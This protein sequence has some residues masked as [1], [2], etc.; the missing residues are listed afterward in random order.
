M[1]LRDTGQDSGLVF[2]RWTMSLQAHRRPA[3]IEGRIWSDDVRTW[4]TSPTA[5][6]R[7]L[8]ALHI[9]TRPPLAKRS[10]CAR[11]PG[12]ARATP[13]RWSFMTSTSNPLSAFIRAQLKIA[14]AHAR[15]APPA[16]APPVAR[17][18]VHQVTIQTRDVLD[19]NALGT[20]LHSAWL[21]QPP[22]RCPWSRPSTPRA[23]YAA[24]RLGAKARET[25]S[26]GNSIADAL[27]SRRRTHRADARAAANALSGWPCRW[28]SSSHPEPSRCA[29]M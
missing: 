16:Q 1:I 28:G 18:H 17:A 3:H 10:C 27:G 29:V 26:P 23:L 11:R 14:L 21:V 9:A 15:R 4:S 24:A 5:V 20:R 6:D 12:F 8:G 13:R 19:A 25:L 7:H 2:H 22:P